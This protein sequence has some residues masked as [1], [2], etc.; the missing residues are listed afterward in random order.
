MDLA[1]N[2]VA[3]ILMVIAGVI[4][5]ILLLTTMSSF[6]VDTAATANASVNLTGYPG[7][8]AVLIGAPWYLY[9][10]PVIIGIAAIVSILRSD[11]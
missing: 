3:Q 4:V 7:S 10:F 1:N 2:K 9:F 5:V 11:K 8:E 6:F